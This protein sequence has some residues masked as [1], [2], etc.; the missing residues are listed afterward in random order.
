[1]RMK[2][3][4]WF[5]LLGLSV[6]CTS[7]ITA[8]L[9]TI[10]TVLGSLGSAASTGS[11]VYK[12][13]KLDSALMCDAA[14]CHHAALLA[15]HDLG[16]APKFDRTSPGADP[17][18]NMAFLDDQKSQVGICIEQRTRC[19]CRCRVDVGLFG[20]EPTARLMMDKIRSH[21]PAG[22]SDR[23]TANAK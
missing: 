15:A 2:M 11:D 8:S 13:G 10:G 4:R 20:S 7:C 16:L 5:L 23:V 19:L 22:A 21:L 6:S 17:V 9:A 1:M 3:L 14:D 12:L 18:W